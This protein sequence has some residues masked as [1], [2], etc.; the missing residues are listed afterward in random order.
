MESSPPLDPARESL[1]TVETFIFERAKCCLGALFV[2]QGFMFVGGLAAIF[3]PTVSL[4][5]PF[6]AFPIAILH[7]WISQ[8]AA[9]F[10]G[11]ADEC[12]RKHELL[13]G[14][15]K[16]PSGKWLA[17]FRLE[18]RG[19]LKPK[20]DALLR[21]G[22]T[23]ASKEPEG[24]RRVLENVAESAWF[25]HHLARWCANALL[26]SLTIIGVGLVVVLLFVVAS[27]AQMESRE[28]ASRA[29]AATFLFLISLGMVK[30]CISY[31]KFSK[32]ADKADDEATSQLK[33]ES[34]S[35]FD[36]LRILSEYQI[37]RASAPMIPTWVWK[38]NK[39]HLNGN[40]DLKQEKSK[41]GND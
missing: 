13:E 7:L 9:R 21:E 29:V 14:F 2:L 40:W 38:I 23:Y 1:L 19:T 28:A 34:P 22:I 17:N 41:H 18:Y 25:S 30:A 20:V 37:A 3:F 6:I 15:G 36:A 27:T 24:A 26:V 11:A 12:K 16:K 33:S 39:K 8:R 5:Y 35:D 32:K 4:N 31:Q 10:K